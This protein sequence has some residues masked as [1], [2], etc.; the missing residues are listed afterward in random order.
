VDQTLIRRREKR[1]GDAGADFDYMAR[2]IHEISP[3]WR[4]LRSTSHLESPGSP[5]S[6]DSIDALSFT[7]SAKVLTAA[8]E[9]G[10]FE[11]YPCPTNREARELFTVKAPHHKRFILGRAENARIVKDCTQEDV[12]VVWSKDGNRLSISTGCAKA[13]A[14]N[15]SQIGSPV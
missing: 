3:G 1:Q 2:F 6:M 8:N 4:G 7:C 9:I 13:S 15:T 5:M 12:S 14:T 10:I 11:E